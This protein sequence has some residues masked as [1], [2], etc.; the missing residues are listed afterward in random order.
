MTLRIA[1]LAKIICSI[2]EGPLTEPERSELN[3]VLAALIEPDVALA[4][5][6]VR[7]QAN[8]AIDL[9]LAGR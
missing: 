5:Y 6:G 3:A 2:L 8:A 9:S 1:H 7:D 4:I